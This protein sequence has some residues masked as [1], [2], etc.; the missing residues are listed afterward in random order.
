MFNNLKYR[1]LTGWNIIRFLRLGLAIVVLSEAW[2]N[3]DILFGI[4]GVVLLTQALLQVGCCSAAGCDIDH[5]K[6]G[7]KSVP[8]EIKDTTFKEN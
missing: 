4:I 8:V 2:K 5:S 6:A 3:E 1:I 7:P